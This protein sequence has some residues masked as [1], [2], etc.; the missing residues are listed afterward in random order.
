VRRWSYP[1]VFYRDVRSGF[2]HELNPTQ[3]ASHNRAGKSGAGVTYRNDAARPYRRIHFDVEWLCAVVERMAERAYPD[4]L[5]HNWR[6]AL[7][8]WIDGA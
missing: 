8:W 7:V 3:F 5:R 1:A 2:D 4:W 6:C